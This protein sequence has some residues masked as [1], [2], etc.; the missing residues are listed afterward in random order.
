VYSN[1]QRNKDQLNPSIL[2]QD[3]FSANEKTAIK[4]AYE[5][6]VTFSPMTENQMISA[7]EILESYNQT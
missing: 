3:V 6:E 4:S 1:E 7:D 2:E 5:R